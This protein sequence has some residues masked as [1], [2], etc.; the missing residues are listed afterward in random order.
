MSK[1]KDNTETEIKLLSISQ[2]LIKNFWQYKRSSVCGTAFHEIDLLKKSVRPA[3][4]RMSLGHYFEYL[5]TGQTLRDGSTPERP[6]TS[7]KKP[8]ADA[9]RVESQAERFKTMIV[10]KDIEIVETGTI[11]EHKVPEHGFKY[12]G[13][14]DVLCKVKG[15]LSVLDI[16]SSGL[17]GN[18]WEAYG[19]D[20]STFNMRDD[21]TLQVV[22]YKW[23]AWKVIGIKDIPFYFAVHSTTNDIDS[24]FWKV[25]LNDFDVSM[26]HFEDMVLSVVS[27]I[28]MNM[29][30]GFTP[31]PDVKRCMSCPLFKDCIY[32]IT[33]PKTVNVVIDGVYVNN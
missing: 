8:T 29:E 12:K 10:E 26:A 22:F 1:Q 20:E 33:V 18:K 25:D 14:L 21:L 32:K 23:L 3:T 6:L 9:I 28:K 19:W 17:I 31:Y 13:V 27:D 2:S 15:E 24:I 30:F 7:T 16:K 5:C 11:W 4:K